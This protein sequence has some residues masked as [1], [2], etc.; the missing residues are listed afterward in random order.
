MM[1][2]QP[3]V[4]IAADADSDGPWFYMII[5]RHGLQ[6][7]IRQMRLPTFLELKSLLF[8]M[9]AAVEQAIKQ[10]EDAERRPQE[11]MYPPQFGYQFPPVTFRLDIG[12]DPNPFALVHI[13]DNRDEVLTSSI[14]FANFEELEAFLRNG[15][16]A[17]NHALSQIENYHR[18]MATG[19]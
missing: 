19:G 4:T 6:E 1:S 14:S 17:F 7:L 12:R 13:D 9:R 10:C 15:A 11:S 3:S 8:S 2:S 5:H 16:N 18:P